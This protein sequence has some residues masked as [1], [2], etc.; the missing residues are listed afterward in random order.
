MEINSTRIR[1]ISSKDVD[2]IIGFV[3]RLPFKI[4]IKGNPVLKGS[5][6]F[7]FFILPENEGLKDYVFEDI[8]IM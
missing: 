8:D 4:E 3:N 2:E 7:L 5:K 1:Y 6:W